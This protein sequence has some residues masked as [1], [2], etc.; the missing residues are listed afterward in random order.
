MSP[1]VTTAGGSGRSKRRKHGLHAGNEF[2][3]AER[4]GDVIV[5]AKIE[6]GNLVGLGSFGGQKDDR[7][8]GD[9]AVVADLAA[10]FKAVGSRHHDV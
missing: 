5:R 10:D 9:A 7:G 8:H 2:A 3:R 6:P 4:L 1:A